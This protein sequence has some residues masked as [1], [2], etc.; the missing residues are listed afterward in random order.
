VWRERSGIVASDDLDSSYLAAGHEFVASLERLGLD[1]EIAAWGFDT[2][3]SKH[4]FVVVTDFFDFKGPYEVSKL[5]FQAYNA[6]ALPQEIDPFLVRLHSG[7]HSLAH[8]VRLL[9]GESRVSARDGTTGKIKADNLVL[10]GG[11]AGGIQF[12]KAWIVRFR[13]SPH[14][15]SIELSRRWRRFERNV[16]ALAA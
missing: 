6:S 15:K 16:E 11:E 3:I 8:S 13:V 2:Q 4:V 7:R 14:R 9:L 10:R 1:P 5:L 12:H